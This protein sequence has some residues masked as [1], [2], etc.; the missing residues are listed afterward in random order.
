MTMKHSSPSSPHRQNRQNE[1]HPP[2]EK[3]SSGEVA[4]L[5]RGTKMTQ[6]G[7]RARP[8]FASGHRVQASSYIVP[9]LWSVPCDLTLGQFLTI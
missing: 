9:L 1:P 7:A 8:H 5:P 3:T 6:E 4:D 2:V